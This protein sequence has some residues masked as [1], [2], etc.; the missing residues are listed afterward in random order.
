MV[1]LCGVDD[2]VPA[3]QAA[4]AAAAL[5]RRAE[6]GL[7]LLHVQDAFVVHGGFDGD[8]AIPVASQALLD[9]ER[10]RVETVLE[11]LAAELARDFGV[12]VDLRFDV[13]FAD[14]QLSR[15]ARELGAALL[16]V[17]AVGRRAHSNW[18][19]GGTAEI[20][21]RCFS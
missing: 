13:G 20:S 11:P 21:G 9:A 14:T 12:R 16:V 8:V 6:D 19:L 17:G 7:E 10:K 5:A 1:F 3:R 18:R 15:R 2:S 4:R